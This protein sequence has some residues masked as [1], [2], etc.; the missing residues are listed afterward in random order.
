VS[1]SLQVGEGVTELLVGDR[2]QCA[3]GMA[4]MV[5][6]Q[7]TS[8]WK[9]PPHYSFA[10][11]ACFSTGY[12]TAYHC[13]VERA[14]LRAG[15][16]CLVHG[17]TGGMGMAAVHIARALGATVIGTGGSEAKLTRVRAQGAA[18]TICYEDQPRFRG[19]VKQLT[20]GRGADV[21]F[22]PVGGAVFDESMYCG[23]YGCRLLV[24]RA[25]VRACVCTCGGAL[26]APQRR[27]LLLCPGSCVLTPT[28]WCRWAL[29]RECAPRHAPTTC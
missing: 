18:H 15:E 11:G 24:V 28:G 12:S 25:C 29:P 4:S 9:L 26:A 21:I 7:A 8:C 10:E 22:D 3:G 27:W 13:L 23:A 16:V 19:T 20:G 2:V 5:M 6:A 17:A 14:R 1:T